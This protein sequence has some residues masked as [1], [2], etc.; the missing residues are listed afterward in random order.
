MVNPAV[1]HEEKNGVLVV[2]F[3][4][5]ANDRASLEI[6]RQYFANDFFDATDGKQQLV[7]DL[8]GVS[9]LDSSSLSPLVQRLREINEDEGKM[10]LCGIHSQGLRE[11]LSLTRFDQIFDIYKDANEAVESV[12]SS[13]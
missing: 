5:D 4:R 10:V 8:S 1:N 7:I 3:E 13:V 12:T 6:V 11:I 9:T 2:S